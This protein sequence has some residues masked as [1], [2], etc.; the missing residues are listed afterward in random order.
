MPSCSH[1][2]ST[3][4]QTSTYIPLP[5]RHGFISPSSRT[6]K[7]LTNRSRTLFLLTIVD[8]ETVTLT[9]LFS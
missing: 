1:L 7:R 5:S 9:D 3:I 6:S 4:V 8:V 2:H